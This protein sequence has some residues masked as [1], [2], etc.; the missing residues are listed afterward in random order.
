MNTE[1]PSQGVFICKDCRYKINADVNGAKNILKRAHAYM[2]W[3][4]TVVTQPEGERS[5]VL[6]TPQ[7][8][9]TGLH[10]GSLA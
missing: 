6:H 1:R 9:L 10:G 5:F 7:P 3:A 2:V 8:P 4:G